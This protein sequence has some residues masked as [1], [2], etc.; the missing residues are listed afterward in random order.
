M[1]E[2]VNS[3]LFEEESV[4][5][6]ASISMRKDSLKFAST[7]SRDKFLKCTKENPLVTEAGY[8]KDVIGVWEKLGEEKSSDEVEVN[9]S[10]LNGFVCNGCHSKDYSLSEDELDADER[11]NDRRQ[12][13]DVTFSIFDIKD[14]IDFIHPAPRLCSRL[15]NVDDTDDF[16][17]IQNKSDIH[18]STPEIFEV[19]STHFYDQLND[20]SVEITMIHMQNIDNPVVLSCHILP[21]DFDSHHP[22]HMYAIVKP[23]TSGK[24]CVALTINASKGYERERSTY[25]IKSII[26]SSRNDLWPLIEIKVDIIPKNGWAAWQ[27][28]KIH[29]KIL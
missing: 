16:L 23:S 14:N 17:A 3:E 8:V 18:I 26:I 9:N 21:I 29:K 12:S 10:Y 6:S 25:G 11:G 7:D 2:S 22:L 13:E 15:F 20:T 24:I 4:S 19:G 28:K 5:T 27:E 1:T